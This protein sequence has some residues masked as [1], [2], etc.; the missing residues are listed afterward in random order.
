MC[1]CDHNLRTPC[2]GKPFCYPPDFT[3]EEGLIYR[4]KWGWSDEVDISPLT[5]WEAAKPR[6]VEPSTVEP[7][8]SILGMEVMIDRSLVPGTVV[9]KDAQ[10]KTLLRIINISPE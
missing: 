4:R 8:L 6:P 1:W 9:I 7:P 2:C 3:K 5:A 10:G